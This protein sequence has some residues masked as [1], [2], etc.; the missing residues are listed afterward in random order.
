MS[1]TKDR[2]NLI[3]AW[4]KH[5]G[6]IPEVSAFCIS[7]YAGMTIHMHC[8]GLQNLMRGSNLDMGLRSLQNVISH[9]LVDNAG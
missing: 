7:T 9:Y 6:D 5:Y 2:D 1:L 8:K 3:K 4:Q